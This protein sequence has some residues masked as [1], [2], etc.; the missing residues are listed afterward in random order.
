MK[1]SHLA[2]ASR[3]SPP[4][5]RLRS[6]FLAAAALSASAAAQNVPQLDPI[7]VNASPES[8]PKVDRSASPKY[9]KP[10]LDTPQTITII[11]DTLTEEQNAH[12]LRRALSNVSGITFNAGEGGGGSGDNIYIR[13]FS[14]SSNIQVDGLRDTAQNRRSDLFNMES[15]EVIKGP[16]SVFGGAGTTGGGV[17]LISKRPRQEDF[18]HGQAGLG[19]PRYGRVALDINQQLQGDAGA[20]RLNFMAHRNAVAERSP[21][22]LRRA[23]I[24]PSVRLNL[25]P[26]TELTLSYFFQADRNVPDYGVP[27]R[28]GRPLPGVPRDAYFGWRNVDRENS[29]T[30]IIS[31]E[32]QHRLEGGGVINNQTRYSQVDR[33]T[34]ISASQVNT[35]GVAAGRYVP[36]GPQGY[37][38]DITT[39]MLA[40]QTSLSTS[41]ELA[42][43]THQLVTGLELSQETYRRR[44]YSEGLRPHFPKEGYF[45][46]SPP[47]IWRGPTLEETTSRHHARMQTRALYAMD[48]IALTPDWDLG[49][50]LRH[51]WIDSSLRANPIGQAASRFK[52]RDRFLNTRAALTYKLAANGRVYLAYGNAFNPSVEPLLVT[53]RGLTAATEHLAPER[54]SSWELGTKW[55]VLNGALALNGALFQITKH[56]ARETFSDGSVRLS[57]Q[58]RVRGLELGAAG[59]LDAQWSLFASYT[60]LDGRTTR[61]RSRPEQVGKPLGNTPRHSLAL[62]TTYEWGSGW[63]AGYGL[64]WVSARPVS[65]NGGGELAAYVVHSA[66]LGYTIDRNLSLQLNIENLTN[67]A[68]IER[69][70]QNPGNAQRSSAVEY[71]DGR[72]VVLTALWRY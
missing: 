52:R 32:L 55:E 13:G 62:W 15:V 48:T 70:R 66:M 44:V 16:N 31:A 54:N 63:Q 22:K 46:A 57:G 36:A 3:N 42:G 38:R 59:K 5:R 27:A 24:A 23:G 64:R 26:T 28:S 37:G 68:Y 20:W 33:D 45:L 21:V 2:I 34:V 14:A 69:V 1:S 65:S 47:G 49:I 40:N 12:S 39:T 51:D 58:Q 9:V 4:P 56:N 71:G 53:G 6:A 17:N 8:G 18:I 72:S 61:M 25:S 43:M 7:S 29:R 60:F 41:F 35:A 19:V 10:L 50:G 11:P 67:A 30:Q